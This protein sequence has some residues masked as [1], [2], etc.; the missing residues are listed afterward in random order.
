MGRVR[1]HGFT[2]TELLIVIA[3]IA[4]LMAILFPV[5]TRERNTARSSTCLSN[6]CSL[7]K[8]LRSY[9]ND[10]DQMFPPGYDRYDAEE[11]P[12]QDQGPYK[13]KEA[14]ADLVQAGSQI[15]PDPAGVNSANPNKG[16]LAPYSANP[17][18]WHCPN[19]KGSP[20]HAR[21]PNCADPPVS[22]SFFRKYGSSYSYTVW[23]DL[24][25]CTATQHYAW[26][27]YPPMVF[28]DGG[29]TPK[30]LS[31]VGRGSDPM[32]LVVFSSIPHHPEPF[33][34]EYDPRAGELGRI[35]CVFA[36]SHVMALPCT[37][38]AGPYKFDEKS[39]DVKS[40]LDAWAK[41][42]WRAKS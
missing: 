26:S 18:I 9:E 17:N 32:T 21:N 30:M 38:S 24:G 4:I 37:R 7:S 29:R 8:A 1:Q 13:F 12:W 3:I 23:F 41:T 39:D 42:R 11:Q 28:C 16:L 5:L 10:H 20:G 14:F 25:A 35:N 2:L 27:G 6:L 34:G 22:P 19:D 40:W 31:D 36:D 33:H 15:H